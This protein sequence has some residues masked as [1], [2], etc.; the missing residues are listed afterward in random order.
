M[1]EEVSGKDHGDPDNFLVSVRVEIR[2]YLPMFDDILTKLLLAS[3]Y[4][5]HRIEVSEAIV[6]SRDVVVKAAVLQHQFY[7][8]RE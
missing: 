8:H 6:R 1:P 3:V 2:T 4:Q 5:F 7:D